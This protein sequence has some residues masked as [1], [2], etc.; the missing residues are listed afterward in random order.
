MVVVLMTKS[1]HSDLRMTRPTHRNQV[2]NN[3]I[4]PN[5]LR[6]VIFCLPLRALFVLAFT[7][8]LFYFITR[9][10]R[11]IND[12]AEASREI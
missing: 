4:D 1:R 9:I 7:L 10:I 3:L 2:I 11:L 5:R 6:A 12:P 8:R